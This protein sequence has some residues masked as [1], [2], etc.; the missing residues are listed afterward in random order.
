MAPENNRREASRDEAAVNGGFV[1][2]TTQTS[3]AQTARIFDTLL[4]SI[5]DLVYIFGRDGRFLYANKRLLDLLGITL[6]EIVGKN[7]HDLPYPP[8]LAHRLQ[9]QIEQVVRTKQIVRDETPFQSPT[10]VDGVY[11]Y[12]FTPVL[13]SRG[14]VDVVAG[15]T[16]D[17]TERKQ[18]EDQ[19][20][21]RLTNIFEQAPAFMSVTRGASHIFEM[22]NPPY[23]QLIGHRDIIGRSVADAIPEVVEQG[24]IT[25]LDQV[26]RTGE[27][28]VGKDVPIQF[29]TT[30]DGPLEERFVDF[31]YQP[32]RDADGLI[33]GILAFGIDLTERRRL[34]TERE[35]LLGETQRRNQ[36]E[37]LL[38]QIGQ[39]IR[40]TDDSDEVQA[41]AVALLGEALGLDLCHAATFDPARD[42]WHVAPDW[43][44]PDLPSL[45]GDYPMSVWRAL[46]EEVVL[47]EGTAVFPDVM[48]ASPPLSSDT[49]ALFARMN[50]RAYVIVPSHDA[51][52][53]PV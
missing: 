18:A 24:F 31:T 22:V 38:Y 19:E 4:S 27:P 33:T 6:G 25:L 36:R 9:Q 20:R 16:R 11:E 3:S 26:Y 35:T 12:I 42:A 10:G 41:Q 45:A 44:R 40:A 15:S 5:V 13:D 53:I 34:E 2:E 14:E 46:S 32:L 37:A 8:E 52:G 7:F 23:Y 39:A 43:H 17:I 29:Q 47:R 28:Y 1:P 51:S 21:A 30:P 49:R 50:V 48:A